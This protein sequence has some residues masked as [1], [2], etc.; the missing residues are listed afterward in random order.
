MWFPQIFEILLL[1]ASL[2]AVYEHLLKLTR[3]NSVNLSLDLGKLLT[4]F[5]NLAFSCG[6][7]HINKLSP[8]ELRTDAVFENPVSLSHLLVCLA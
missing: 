5:Q 7:K 2:R 3:E 6:S 1:L 8:E 4:E